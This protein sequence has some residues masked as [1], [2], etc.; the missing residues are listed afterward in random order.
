MIMPVVSGLTLG[1]AKPP[2]LKLLS[3]APGARCYEGPL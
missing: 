3:M 1:A 2:L